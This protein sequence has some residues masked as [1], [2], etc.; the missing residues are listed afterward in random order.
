MGLEVQ[1]DGKDE[2]CA[3]FEGVDE[4]ISAIKSK[5]GVRVRIRAVL[6]KSFKGQDS[7]WSKSILHTQFRLYVLI[8]IDSHREISINDLLHIAHIHINAEDK[9]FDLDTDIQLEG[10]FELGVSG[11]LVKPDNAV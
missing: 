10:L 9:D 5:I 4:L 7:S 8:I 2:V 1:F 11:T 3:S 6:S